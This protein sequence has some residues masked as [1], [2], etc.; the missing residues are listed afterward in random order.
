MVLARLCISK[1][2]EDILLMLEKP[3]SR[4]ELQYELGLGASTLNRVMNWLGE[5]DLIKPVYI[6][7]KKKWV[8]NDKGKKLLDK[9]KEIYGILES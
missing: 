4:I 5:H 2:I 1:R 3:R 9:L 8:L 7:G 6:E